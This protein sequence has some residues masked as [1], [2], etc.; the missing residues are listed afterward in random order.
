MLSKEE[1]KNRRERFFDGFKEFMYGT[2]S[3][4]GYRLNWMNYP[5]RVKNIR[6]NLFADGKQSLVALDFEHKNEGMRELHFEQILEC[7]TVMT[8]CFEHCALEWHPQFERENGKHIARVCTEPIK[9]NLYDEAQW[10]TMYEYLKKG[11]QSM[12]VFWVEF[13]AIYDD[14]Q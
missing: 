7:K 2:K 1:V 6:I 5:T 13:G 14:L 3:S 8:K 12:D 11:I 10:P 9:S 4:G